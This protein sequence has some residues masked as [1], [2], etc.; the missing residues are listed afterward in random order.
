MGIFTRFW[1]GKHYDLLCKEFEVVK[2]EYVRQFTFLNYKE[3]FNF[4]APYCFKDFKDREASYNEFEI[5]KSKYRDVVLVVILNNIVEYIIEGGRLNNRQFS[6]A[7]S[8][9][10]EIVNLLEKSGYYSEEK[11]AEDRKWYNKVTTEMYGW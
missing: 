8:L 5:N 3:I 10:Y 6:G 7:G 11:A 9:F 2:E 1:Y 4:I